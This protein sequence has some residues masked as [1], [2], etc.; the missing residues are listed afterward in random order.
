MFI[1]VFLC[2]L[3]AKNVR[4][5]TSKNVDTTKNETEKVKQER[6]EKHRKKIKRQYKKIAT[7]RPLT[8]EAQVRDVFS[9]CGICVALSEVSLSSSV[10]TIN[11]IPPRI[12]ILIYYL[13]DEQ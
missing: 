8:T 10:Y 1:F 11:I 3:T 7:P 12:S 5:R 6:K 4:V 13:G 9:P 2:T